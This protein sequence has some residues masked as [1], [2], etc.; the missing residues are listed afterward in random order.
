MEQPLAECSIGAHRRAAERGRSYG[1][2][3]GMTTF[4][5]KASQ[6][7]AALRGADRENAHHSLT[8]LG[9]GII[10]LLTLRFVNERDPSMRSTLVNVAWQT[11]AAGALALLKDALNDSEPSVWKEALDGLSA[12]G[13]QVALE[14][15][16]E[17]RKR[18]DTPKADWLDEAIEQIAG[19]MSASP[20][21][22]DF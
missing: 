10:P 8:E 17:A 14:V 15:V 21:R 4:E 18:A 2:S 13:G 12:V 22:R 20:A 19:Q 6:F 3:G 16:R 5:E 7:I 11:D 1:K 9:Q